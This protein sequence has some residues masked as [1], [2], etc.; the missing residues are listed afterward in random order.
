[1]QLEGQK[2]IAQNEIEGMRLAGDVVKTR[3]AG[4]K[5]K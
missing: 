3:Q 1:M 2:F 5:S 4:K